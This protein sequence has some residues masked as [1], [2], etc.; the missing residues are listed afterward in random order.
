MLASPNLS[1]SALNEIDVEI[2]SLIAGLERLEAYKT[3]LF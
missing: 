1:F 3:E 2:E